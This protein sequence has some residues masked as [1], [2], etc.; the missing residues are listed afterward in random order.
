MIEGWCR[1]KEYGV[2]YQRC[3]S[4]NVVVAKSSYVCTQLL[5][6]PFQ[7]RKIRIKVK[8]Q[9]NFLIIHVCKCL[10]LILTCMG[11]DCFEFL[12]F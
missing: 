9:K 4:V 7:K 10:K 8:I 11:T 6:L 2:H 3:Y 1:T 12:K 5:D